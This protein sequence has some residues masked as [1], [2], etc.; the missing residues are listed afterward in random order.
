MH[1]KRQ[2][3]PKRWP[4]ERKGTTYVVR[5]S[6]NLKNG[7]PI[8]VVLRNMLNLAK[9]RKE[10]KR[11]IHLKQILVNGK[12]VKDEKNAVLLFDVV[13]IVP[14]KEHYRVELSAAKKFDLR[15]IKEAEAHE[16]VAKIIGKKMLKGKKTQINLSDG[17]NIISETKCNV[18][19]S[20]VLNFKNKKADKC[21]P[22]KE[23]A[24][25]VVFEGKHT[26]ESGK[27]EKIDLE[28]K[29]AEIN[30]EGKKVNVLIKQII[31]VN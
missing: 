6:F 2:E 30:S 20:L 12:P 7:I 16:K 25:V 3:V 8:L 28:H 11:A 24:N 14:S 9:N 27:V 17:N 18:N 5:P 22:L 29:M 31:V 15:E 23:N 1:L 10:V 4:I 19:D 13:S 21:L 26:G